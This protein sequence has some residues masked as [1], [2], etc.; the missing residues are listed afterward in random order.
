MTKTQCL[1]PSGSS[2]TFAILITVFHG[3]MIVLIHPLTQIIS[4]VWPSEDT[5]C[6]GSVNVGLVV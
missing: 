5:N 1:T 4:L 3:S 6:A 2:E